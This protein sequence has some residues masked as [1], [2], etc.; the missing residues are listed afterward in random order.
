[1]KLRSPFET[2]FGTT[3]NRRVLLVEVRSEGATGWAEITTP[4][5]PFYNAETT[6]SA[7]HVFQDFIVPMVLGK[8]VE[9]AAD[10]TLLMQGIRGNEMARAGFENALWV[11]EAIAKQQPLSKLLGGQREEIASGVSLGIQAD[12]S[13]LLEKIQQELEAGYRRIK[14][15]I[16]PGMDLQVV[17]QVREKYPTIPL[18]VDANSAYRLEDAPLLK[19]LDA[20]DLMM[21]EQPLNWDDIYLHSLLQKQLKTPICLDECIHNAG[22]ARAAIEMHA[23]GI[24]NIKLGRVG[25]H[26]E[27][28]HIHDVCLHRNVPVW[29]GGMLES[30]V[31]RAHNVAMSA[32]PGFVLPGDVSASRRYWEE[33]IIE[34]E[35]EVRSNGTIPV[36]K[37]PGLGYEVNEDRVK[38]LTVREQEWRATSEVPVGALPNSV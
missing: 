17:R 27:A 37:T 9:R 24:I 30:G 19:E 23:C 29:C 16:K 18:M 38:R 36:P 26:S 8:S 35:I 21:I 3:V 14:L 33:D 5:G 25:G 12:T 20:F 34:P 1:M 11:I 28:R 2:S 31:G 15:K 7:W 6:D 32:L 4:E 10:A 22:H 13:V